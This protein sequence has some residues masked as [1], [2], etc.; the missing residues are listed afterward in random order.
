MVVKFLPSKEKRKVLGEQDFAHVRI[1]Q[2]CG[3]PRRACWDVCA[4]RTG[5]LT[6]VPLLYDLASCSVGKRKKTFDWL[7][8]YVY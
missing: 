4:G 5:L 7:C 8:G 1:L 6:M 3:N 2:I